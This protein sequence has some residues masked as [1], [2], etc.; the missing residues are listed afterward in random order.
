M[1][2]LSIFSVSVSANKYRLGYRHGGITSSI[3]RSLKSDGTQVGSLASNITIKGHLS[4]YEFHPLTTTGYARKHLKI[5]H[6]FSRERWSKDG[7]N[8][9]AVEGSNGILKKAKRYDSMFKPQDS[10]F[11]LIEYASAKNIKYFGVVKKIV[12]EEEL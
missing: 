6:V 9:N 8:S 2:R 12:F 7:V 3:C 11:Y 10:T 5:I 4:F 1:D